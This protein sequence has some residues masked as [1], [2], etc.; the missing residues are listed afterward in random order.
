MD[1]ARLRQRLAESA[2]IVGA[3][4]GS[5][6]AAAAAEDG[7]ADFVLVLSAGYFRTHGVGSMAALMPYASANELSWRI[8][9]MNVVP[10]LRRTPVLLGLCA[11]DPQLDLEAHL[12]QLQGAGVAGVANYPTVGLYGEAR[13]ALEEDG[14]TFASEVA[15]LTAA[16]QRGLLTLGFCLTAEDAAAL[17]RARVDILCLNLGPAEYRALEGDAHQA[18]LDRGVATVARM[19]AA[20]KAQNSAAFCIASGGPLVMPQDAALLFQ[21]T[22]VLGYMGGSSIERFPTA[23]TVTQTVREFRHAA[24]SGQETH[25]LGAMIGVGRAMKEVFEAIRAVAASDA[26][27]L[28]IGESGTGKE[29]AAREIHR[30][31]HLN[32]RPLVG[33]NCG[34]MT[35]SLA[36]SELFGHD[37]GAFTGATRTH[38]GKFELA[39]GGTLFMDEVTDLPLSVQAALLRVL[40]QREIVRVGGEKTMFVDVRVIAASNKDFR[41]LIPDGR[42]RL[43][44][45]YRLS[46][47]VIR[48]PALRDRREDIPHL[49]REIAAKAAQKHARPAPR[50]TD[51]AMG[52]L[53]RHIW[54]GNIRELHNTVE[55]MF[56]LGNGGAPSR[57]WLE[58]LLAADRSLGDKLCPS[59]SPHLSL[60]ARR[61]RLQ[62]V[63]ARHRGNRS[64]AARELGVSRKTIHE[65]LRA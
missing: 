19:I 62:E 20:A 37:K 29:L 4:L 18:A 40:Q 49:V 52:V 51:S 59:T 36:M 65:W 54:P 23:L 24:T 1:A 55:R 16:K 50:L 10:R 64:A 41:D 38:V 48:M 31:S 61:A 28:I 12:G 43:D 46:T 5:G 8:A 11:S 26:T 6:M 13:R 2:R 9:R 44:L 47:I 58:D 35:E 34:S 39:N 15:M 21:R 57:A 25:R 33:W 60:T 7:D 63:L 3:A 45:Y 14:V 56:L 30:L 42:F 27:V 22:T 17:A 53:V 32:G